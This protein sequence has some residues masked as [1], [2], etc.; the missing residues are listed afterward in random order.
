MPVNFRE[1]AEFWKRIDKRLKILIKNCQ[2]IV[3]DF[4]S[5][6]HV[7][8]IEGVE[9]SL[10]GPIIRFKDKGLVYHYNVRGGYAKDGLTYKQI[11]K[12]ENKISWKMFT[13]KEIYANRRAAKFHKD[14]NMSA[15]YSVLTQLVDKMNK[16][17]A[18]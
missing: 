2:L 9:D 4:G 3:T 6:Y 18:K 5:M 15:G 7:E 1:E 11:E 17:A 14:F 12:I 16:A 8:D 13:R 10:R